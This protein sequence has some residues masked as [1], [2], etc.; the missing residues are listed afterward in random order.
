MSEQSFTGMTSA[1]A[2]GQ[3]PEIGIGLLG[4]AFMGKA[5]SNAYIKIPYMMY[6]PPPFPS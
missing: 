5:H 2:S 6:P 4:Y 1:R 3:V